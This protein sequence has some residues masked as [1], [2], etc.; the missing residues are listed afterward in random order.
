MGTVHIGERIKERREAL[1]WG[2]ERLAREANRRAGLNTLT[3]REIKRYEDG[4][5]SPV[6]WL[7]FLVQALECSEESLTGTQG[8]VEP[9][10][11]K[12]ADFLPA[13]DPLAPLK[14]H[15]RRIGIREVVD[16]NGRVHGLRLADDVIAGRDLMRPALREL[17]SAVRLRRETTHDE[18]VGTNLLVAI[19]ELA[20]ITGWIASD[21]GRHEEAE[22]VYRLGISAAHEAGDMTLA[23][24]LLGSLAYQTT[25][26]GDAQEGVQMAMAA[27]EGAGDQAPARARALYW[28]RVAW[29]HTKVGDTPASQAA[30]RALGEAGEA[31]TQHAGED[32]PAYLYWVDSGE[33][34]VMEA[35]VYTELHRPLRAVP[36]LSRV[37]ERY[38][39]SHAR[40]LALYLSWLA[41]AYADA[42]EP[43]QAAA[44]ASRM[45]D[46]SGGVASD[47]T[48]ER[49]KLVIARLQPYAD[50]PEVREVLDRQ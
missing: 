30:M 26:T 4:D 21:A 29:A 33:L 15:G 46:L 14:A 24:N 45:L 1:G 31:L 7:P 2:R 37:L 9:P 23:G 17:R 22:R 50:V 34:E 16:L 3:K 48:D 43:E 44:T 11:P 18:A 38:D 6:S 5:R 25:N 35:R 13:G 10:A 28:D 49:S 8:P 42:N 39:T 41:V 19:G 20:Q 36:L 12:V 47:R 27:L 32:E 40:E